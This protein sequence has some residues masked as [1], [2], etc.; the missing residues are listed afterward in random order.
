MH[1]AVDAAEAGE[2]DAGESSVAEDLDRMGCVELGCFPSL[3]PSWSGCGKATCSLAVRAGKRVIFTALPALG[4]TGDGKV[5]CI[6]V[7]LLNP[8]ILGYGGSGPP[9]WSNNLVLMQ[10][11]PVT[12]GRDVFHQCSSVKLYRQHPLKL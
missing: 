1:D 11:W 9:F 10:D 12:E 2:M 8:L 5:R 4:G 6:L 3:G 7:Y